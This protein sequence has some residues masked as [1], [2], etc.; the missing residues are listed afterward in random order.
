MSDIWGEN[1]PNPNDFF[2]TVE[3]WDWEKRFDVSAYLNA[4]DTWVQNLMAKITQLHE[5]LGEYES[6]EWCGH[7]ILE[8]KCAQIT[9]HAQELKE[10]A[11]KWGLA[12]SNIWDE[13]SIITP[14]RM[15]LGINVLNQHFDTCETHEQVEKQIDELLEFE[16]KLE[17]IKEHTK[18]YPDEK[19]TKYS[20][21]R[22]LNAPHPMGPSVFNSVYFLTNLETWFKEFNEILGDQTSTDTATEEIK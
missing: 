4:R 7:C 1:P 19:D 9:L 6:K 3:R 14:E 10:R 18:T 13:E 15:A 5:C 22:P 16:D 11:E 20:Q 8:S 21:G 17:A 2:I 12:V